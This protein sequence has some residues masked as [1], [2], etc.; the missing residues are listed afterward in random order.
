MMREVR[1]DKTGE[2]RAEIKNGGGGGLKNFV[3]CLLK[4]VRGRSAASLPDMII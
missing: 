4:T 1:R 2:D 3:K